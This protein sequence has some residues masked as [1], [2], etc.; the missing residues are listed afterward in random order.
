ML[1][2]QEKESLAFKLILDELSLEEKINAFNLITTDDEFKRILVQEKKLY[3]KMQSFKKSLNED[4]SSR[5]FNNIMD[6]VKTESD[7]SIETTNMILEELLPTGLWKLINKLSEG[8]I[9]YGF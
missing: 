2:V 4:S 5:I 6:E 1:R 7:L 9:I 3:N 8:R